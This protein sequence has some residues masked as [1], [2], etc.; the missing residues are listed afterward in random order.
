MGFKMSNINGLEISVKEY[1][2]QRGKTVQAVYQQMKR[3]EN[4]AALEGHVTLRT[5]G[6]KH[7]KYLDEVA[8]SVLDSASSSAPLTIIEDGLKESLVAAEQEKK[9]WEAQAF[10]LQGQVELLQGMLAEKEQRLRLLDGVQG[11]IDALEAQN[12]DLRAELDQE[13][14]KAAKAEETAQKA[15][16]EL[17]SERNRPLTFREW[18]QRRKK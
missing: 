17:E 1:A 15:L 16:Q 3:K 14:V 10:K 9:Q 12:G 4:A 6:N 11:R 2:A 13:K 7:V 18:W 8:V 5:V